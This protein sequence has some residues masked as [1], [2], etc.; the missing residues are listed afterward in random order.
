MMRRQLARSVKMA[1][2]SFFL[3]RIPVLPPPVVRPRLGA[4][5]KFNAYIP[6]SHISPKQTVSWFSVGLETPKSS[7]DPSKVLRTLHRV[8]EIFGTSFDFSRVVMCGDQS[9]GKTSVLE[10]LIGADISVKED[11]MATRRPLLLTLIRIRSGMYAQFKDGEKLY[12]FE[13]SVAWS[14]ILPCLCLLKIITVV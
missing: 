3:R 8:Q 12:S 13:G 4:F 7:S 2:S 9:S 6:S 5:Q 1:T 10:A 11:K 14:H